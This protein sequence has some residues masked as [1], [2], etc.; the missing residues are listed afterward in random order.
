MFHAIILTI[1]EGI[2]A[3]GVKRP[4]FHWAYATR[5]VLT[6]IAC[7]GV[8][9]LTLLADPLL[10]VDRAEASDVFDGL[11]CPA[12]ISVALVG[13]HLSDYAP[14]TFGL[15][16]HVARLPIREHGVYEVQLRQR[17]LASAI[18]E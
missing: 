2:V 1:H 8:H 12:C 6:F 3:D 5:R 4:V 18:A 16:E 7:P 9:V 14:G 10:H 13:L 17:F 11:T 15:D